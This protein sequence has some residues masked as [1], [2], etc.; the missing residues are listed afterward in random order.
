M[1]RNWRRLC[2]G[3]GLPLKMKNTVSSESKKS[4]PFKPVQWKRLFLFCCTKQD[5]L[6]QSHSQQSI[7]FAA[8][9]GHQNQL[10]RRGIRF[11]FVTNAVEQ[12]R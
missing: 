7:W 1:K 5:S 6:F 4:L 10:Q 9:F 3:E 12:L 8:L 11:P 2:S